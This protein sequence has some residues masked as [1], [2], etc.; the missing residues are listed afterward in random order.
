MLKWEG[1]AAS[2]DTVAA[3]LTVKELQLIIEKGR[4]SPK[5]FNIDGTAV[6]WK[7]DAF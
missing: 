1:E 2:A 7:K 4:Y 3:E 5:I 6:F